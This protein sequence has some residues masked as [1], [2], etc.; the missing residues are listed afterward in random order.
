MDGAG[1]HAWGHSELSSVYSRLLCHPSLTALVLTPSCCKHSVGALPSIPASYS[2]YLH[3]L[4]LPCLVMEFT[5]GATMLTQLL[6][7]PNLRHLEV[8]KQWHHP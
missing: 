4:R 3:T 6:S 7:A 8:G 5:R 1:G 2:V